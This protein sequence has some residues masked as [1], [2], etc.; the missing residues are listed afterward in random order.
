MQGAQLQG[1]L[2]KA[3]VV[4]TL[5]PATLCQYGWKTRTALS[6]LSAC[7]ACQAGSRLACM[8]NYQGLIAAKTS[9]EGMISTSVI[10]SHSPSKINGR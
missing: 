6:P 8:T 5:L 1:G 2:P 3:L 7:T 9:V 4:L 10:E